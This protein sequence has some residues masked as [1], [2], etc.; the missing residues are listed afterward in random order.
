[1]DDESDQTYKHI[2]L[3][4]AT[5]LQEGR[6]F[7]GADG[8]Y[9]G[10]LLSL[11]VH[12][13]YSRRGGNMPQTAKGFRRTIRQRQRLNLERGLSGSIARN[14]RDD[15]RQVLENLDATLF[16]MLG[17][18][19]EH[20]TADWEKEAVFYIMFG[21]N[22]PIKGKKLTVGATYGPVFEVYPA[23]AVKGRGGAFAGME[24]GPGR[25]NIAWE[26]I[27]FENISDT[28]SVKVFYIVPT[29]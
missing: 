9:D 8:S 27:D 22:I 17:F 28:D 19:E 1:M 16:G 18:R 20:D 14:R 10:E 21:G 5:L 2:L 3:A 7:V 26:K 25:L 23:D 11:G 13:A 12:G 24:L 4:D 15:L 6:T 29:R